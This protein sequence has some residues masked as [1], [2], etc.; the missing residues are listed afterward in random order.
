MR[1]FL[2]GLALIV[3]AFLVTTIGF[4]DEGVRL[5]TPLDLPSGGL[6]PDDEE[7][8]APETITFY[9]NEIEGDNF[10][11]VFPAYGFCGVFTAFNLIKQEITQSMNQLSSSSWMGLVAFNI[12]TPHIWSPTPKL[13]TPAHKSSARDPSRADRSMC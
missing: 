11:W 4:G 13:A 7:E 1:L 8:D 3:P 10:M 5:K 9:G 6:S 2:I 12:Q